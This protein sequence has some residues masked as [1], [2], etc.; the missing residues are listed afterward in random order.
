MADAQRR[1]VVVTGLGAVTPIG[2]TVAEFWNA[3]LEGKN[4]ISKITH[5][6]VDDMPCQI[7]GMVK[8][9]DASTV[10]DRK[11]ARQTDPF[12][13][14]A[15]AAA[16]EAAKDAGIDFT[17]E[18]PT[19]SG[20]ILGSGI[21]GMQEIQDGAEILFARGPSRQSPFFIP[22]LMLNAAA[23]QLAINFGI[24]GPNW[25]CASACASTNHAV[26]SAMRSIQYGDAD[27]MF[28][29]G[30]E[31]TI[32]RLGMSGFCA[33]RAMATDRNED[34]EHA[35]RPFDK[36][37]SGFVMGEGGG[38]LLL[39]ELNHAKKRGAK[40]YA[41]L[42]GYGAS[43]D[44]YHI[45]SPSESGVGALEC[46][47]AAMRDGR[48]NQEDITYV[49]AHGTSTLY[50]DR[51]ESK[52]IRAAL[53]AHADKALVSSTKSMIGHLLGGS[54]GVELVAAVMTIHTG[55]VHPT[56]NYEVADPE[57]DLNYVPNTAREAPVKAVLKNSFGFGGHN[58]TI[59]LRRF[60]G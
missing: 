25:S 16:I 30:S 44:A 36:N 31:A 39:E 46:M 12:V 22:K 8:G 34:P 5:I 55:R 10:L 42:C 40:I 15:L 56:R 26:G 50:N 14:F 35:S 23:G 24:R 54:G 58:A 20:V 6:K 27:I 60:E 1:R 2:N 17:K 52:A 13:H 18:D 37:R 45:T 29:G 38:I 4:G 43:D 47:T 57:C 41:E 33:A 48:L 21:G 32:G 7:A 49:N 59:A 28:T 51:T 3:A 11:L 19:R 9:F 53:G